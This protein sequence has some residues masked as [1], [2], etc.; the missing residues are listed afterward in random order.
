MQLLPC[1]RGHGRACSLPQSFAAAPRPSASS[2]GSGN[3]PVKNFLVFYSAEHKR[4]QREDCGTVNRRSTWSSCCRA[5]CAGSPSSPGLGAAAGGWGRGVPAGWTPPRRVPHLQGH[6]TAP[7]MWGNAV[8][9][10]VEGV[11]PQQCC[12]ELRCQIVF[13]YFIIF[14]SFQ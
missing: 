5:C 8:Q 9:K 7:Q 13:Y 1:S 12:G 4:S 10:L 14:F 6:S 2:K 11:R 3:P